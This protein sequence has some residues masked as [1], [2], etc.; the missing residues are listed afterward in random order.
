MY[1]N[2]YIIMVDI[3]STEYDVMS[4]CVKVATTQ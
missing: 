2:G 1:Y 4:M 3:V